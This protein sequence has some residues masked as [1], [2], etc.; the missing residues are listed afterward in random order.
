MHHR[1][2]N[3]QDAPIIEQL[4][5]EIWHLHYPS[6]LSI[7]QI[8]FM[9][10]LQYTVSAVANSIKNGAEWYIFEEEGREIGF[11]SCYCIDATTCK[12]DKLYI[13]PQHQG[14]GFGRKAIELAA[15]VA[16]KHGASLLLLNVNRKN[17]NSIKAYKKCGFAILRSEDNQLGEYLLDDYVMCLEV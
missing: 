10:S 7:E 6:I 11:L 12:L 9:L 5:H 8:D 14:K 4:A 2:A 17:L 3:E 13:H 15:S 1:L 16:R